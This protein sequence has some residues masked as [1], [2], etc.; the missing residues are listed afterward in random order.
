[1]A[2]QPNNTQFLTSH[3]ISCPSPVYVQSPKNCM[4][5][6]TLGLVRSHGDRRGLRGIKSFLF[7]FD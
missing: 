7:N 2:Y 4:F 5:S 1:M 3:G 6:I